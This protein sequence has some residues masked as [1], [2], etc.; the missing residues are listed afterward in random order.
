[1]TGAR[2]PWRRIWPGAAIVLYPIGLL[3]ALAV[4]L[5]LGGD[6]TGPARWALVVVPLT[7]LALASLV[8]RRAERARR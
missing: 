3:A 7:L 6:E 5:M 4:A 2:D 8:V 1:M